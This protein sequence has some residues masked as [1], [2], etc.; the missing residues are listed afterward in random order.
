M[1]KGFVHYQ[2]TPYCLGRT[3]RKE[4]RQS[5]TTSG[6]LGMVETKSKINS[7]FSNKYDDHYFHS[8]ADAVCK[9]R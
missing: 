8:E 2:R 9:A 3:P 7:G 1:K 5:F 6:T 4:K